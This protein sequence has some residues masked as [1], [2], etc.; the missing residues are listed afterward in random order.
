MGTLLKVVLALLVLIFVGCA[1]IF[2]L[3]PADYEVSRKVTIAA[4]SEAIHPHVD[5]LKQWPA[6]SVWNKENDPAL[7]VAYSG[8]DRGV[9]AISTWT[10]K[11]GPGRMEI[12]ASYP[13]KGV[14]YDMS[15]GE[16]DSALESKGVVMYSSGPDGTTVTMVMRGGF[17]GAMK[18]L[19]W[20]ADAMMGPL[21]ESSLNGLARVVQAQPAEEPEPSEGD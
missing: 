9:G 12:T 15:F 1:G 10:S 18:P 17:P 7:E 13:A 20:G 8:E 3:A 16:G 6:W 19:N 21:F 11:D 4:P 14:W 5:D 2:L